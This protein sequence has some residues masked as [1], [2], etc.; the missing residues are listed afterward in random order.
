MT[1]VVFLA[2]WYC[3][4]YPSALFFCSFSLVMSYFVDRFSLMRSWAPSP[5]IGK[6]IS[7]ISRRY[8]MPAAVCISAIMASY[9]WT[10]FNFDNLCV[11]Y[12]FDYGTTDYDGTW[13]M[14]SIKH[15]RIDRAGGIQT[16]R[17]V[18]IKSSKDQLYEFCNQNFLSER[19]ESLK[20]PALP[21]YQPV[22][23]HWMS[24]DQERLTR[25]FGWSS[26]G[27]L[28][29]VVSFY[30][31]V[32]IHTLTK[33]YKPKGEDKEIPFSASGT[34]G[35]VPQVKSDVI[36]FPLIAC[37][38][39]PIIDDDLIDWASPFYSYE[40]FDLTIDADKIMDRDKKGRSVTDTAFSKVVHWEAPV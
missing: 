37:P 22:G 14:P 38:V 27:I 23:N 17:L 2:L 12:S 13:I 8:F 7:R 1:K 30:I 5:K 18:D 16:T 19:R 35:Y 9:M 26:V 25:V 21:S 29:F 32:V 33:S 10:S 15:G 11:V 20:F 6:I 24:D 4:I 28:C 31:L 34:A 40:N 39:Q 3:P 36:N